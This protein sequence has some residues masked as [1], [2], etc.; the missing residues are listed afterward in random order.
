[1]N[2]YYST[3]NREQGGTA[4]ILSCRNR[5]VSLEDSGLRQG[6]FSHY[7]IK[8]LKGAADKNSNKI[9]TVQELFNF[10]SSQVQ[11]Y[12]DHVQNPK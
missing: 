8:G 6:I 1:M 10:I 11:S 5:E 3:F 12:T 2:N 4:F 9:V 7:L